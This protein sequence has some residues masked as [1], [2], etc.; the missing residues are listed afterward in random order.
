MFKPLRGLQF[1]EAIPRLSADFV[2]VQ[3]AALISLVYVLFVQINKSPRGH[4][5]VT[6]LL[7][8]GYYLRIFLPLSLIFPI[9]FFLDGVYTHLRCYSTKYKWWA[10][11]KSCFI[12]AGFFLAANFLVT[13][14]ALL[15]R[16][17]F[18][19]FVLLVLC[20]TTGI[21]KIKHYLFDT[22]FASSSNVP[23]TKTHPEKV[24][25][26][27]GAGYI[28]SVLVRKLL[29]QECKVRV[30]DSLIYGKESLEGIRS[31]PNLE[32]IVGDCRNIQSVVSAM[33]DIHSVVDLAAIV[34]D[35]ACNLDRKVAREINYAA[36]RMILEVAKGN[37]VERLVFASSCSVYGTSEFLVDENGNTSPV[38]LYAETKVDSEN[39]LLLSGT[40]G[41]H[42]TI[43][44][45]ATVFGYS[46]R[47]RFDL[48]VNFLTAKAKQD[49]VITI[50]NGQ[51]WRPFIH[52]QDVAEAI[53]GILRAPLAVVNGEIFNVGDAKLNYTLTEV[54]QQICKLLPGTRVEHAVN[55]DHRNYRVSFDKI[56]ERL[57][58]NCA[59]S[60][61][62]G[63][64]EIKQAVTTRAVSHYMDCK[65]HNDRFLKQADVFINANELDTEV[66][67]AFI[68]SPSMLAN[69]GQRLVDRDGATAHTHSE[70]RA[71][72]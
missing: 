44:R 59:V 33:K 66:M 19:L 3:V 47:P 26:V 5:D 72:V 12:A 41:F 23:G 11:A 8:Q 25:V 46:Y 50:F 36:T 24:L 65:Y 45:L 67:A 51:Q 68:R 14:V 63:I 70:A 18:L 60:L 58:F 37:G 28:G 38:S 43:L 64:R 9:V 13:R 34:G 35:P 1:R 2:I 16:G 42:P 6:A 30:L 31:H 15:A 20:G 62:E 32:L 22:E 29:E 54:A 71:S 4:A 10:V 53:V 56:K 52:V 17:S 48:V 69:G 49:G 55:T 7:L 40:D 61:E 57:G 39:V 21:R 27:G